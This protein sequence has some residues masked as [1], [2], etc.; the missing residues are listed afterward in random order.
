MILIKMPQHRN[1]RL[2]GPRGKVLCC[3]L[4]SDH[5]LPSTARK[6]ANCQTPG[7]RSSRFGLQPRRCWSAWLL[8]FCV[9]PLAIAAALGQVSKEY[10]LKAVFLWRLAQFTEWPP[11]AFESAASPIVIGVLGE[12]PFGDVLEAV[13]RGETAHGRK[14]VL[15]H[16]SHLDQIKSC[17]VLY[18]STSEARRVKETVEALSDRTIL[19]VSDIDGFAVSYGGMIRFVTD[20]N[21]IK[22]RINLDAVTAA[23]LKLDARLLRASEVIRTR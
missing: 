18:I 20:Q 16:Y 7:A 5:A 8:L 4:S 12:N 10:H 21:K 22:L 23:Q 6:L 19:T 9:L 1:R 15:Q 17:H 3:G 14:L 2:V 13:V 11:S